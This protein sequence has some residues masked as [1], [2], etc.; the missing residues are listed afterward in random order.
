M[1]TILRKVFSVFLT[2]C[3]WTV[4]LSLSVLAAEGDVCEIVETGHE[5]S[6]LDDALA[7]VQDEETIR[8][9]ES[10]NYNCGIVIDAED[11]TFKL[12]EFTLNVVNNDGPGLRV[13]NGGAVYLDAAGTGAFN[14]TGKEF[15]V[16]V[17]GGVTGAATA[18]V[19][20]AEATAP[21]GCAA[22][23]DGENAVITVEGDVTAN[24]AGGIGAIGNSSGLVTVKGNVN[25]DAGNVD[26]EG[27]CEYAAVAAW[28]D[29]EVIVAGDVTATGEKSIGVLSAGSCVTVDG[30]VA[31]V[32]GGAYA[33]ASASIEI[34]GN[35]RSTDASGFGV[36]ASDYCGIDIGGNV[37]AGGTGVII[38]GVAE[39][40]GPSEIIIDGVIEAPEYIKIGE[41]TL[42]FEDY[43]LDPGEMP[44]YRIYADAS[45]TLGGVF[46]AEF[47]GGD[48]SE[49]SPYLVAHAYHL[50]NVRNYLDKCFR[51][52]EDI[53]LSSYNSDGGWEPLGTGD[54]S[55]TGIYDGD[56][57]TISNLF[58]SRNEAD[59]AGL[60]GRILC[61]AAGET[62]IRD[63]GLVNV[64][65]TSKGETGGLAGLNYGATMKNCY[66]T[67]TV[68]GKG[69]GRIGGLV[70]DNEGDIINCYTNATVEGDFE[71]LVDYV[72]G[73]V[74]MNFGSITDSHSNG[75]VSGDDEVGGLVGYNCAYEGSSGLISDSYSSC[76]VTGLENNVGGLVG[77]NDGTITDSFATGA[78]SG[79]IGVGGLVGITYG[80]ISNSYAAGEVEGKD[81]VGGLAG[82]NYGS[83][84]KSYATG[85]VT[86]TETD[87]D[88]TY[89]GGLVGSNLGPISDSYAR[90]AVF[91]QEDIGG[92]VGYNQAL[93]ANSYATGLVDGD[94]YIGGL[95]G[96]NH[97][98]GNI[99]NSYWDTE[100]SC[101]NTSDGG[102]GKTTAEMK[103][104]ATYGDWDFDTI[105]EISAD[106]N[107]GYPY[108][109]WLSAGLTDAE[110][111]A[112]DQTA[113]TFAAIKGENSEEGNIT[114]GLNLVSSG[115]NGTAI[116]WSVLPDEGW[117]NPATGAVTRPSF[118]TGS[119]AVTLT[120]T[121]SKGSASDTRAFDLVVASLPPTEA[122]AVAA[123]KVLLTW[124]SIKGANRSTDSVTTGLNLTSGGR[125]DTAI[126]WSV[127]P[128]ENWINP[129]TGAVTR[130]TSREGDQ[131]VTLTATIAKGEASDT[132]EFTL[133]VKAKSVGSGGGGS[134]TPPPTS[135]ITD[136][137]V[138]AGD[139]EMDDTLIDTGEAF[140]S[141]AGGSSDT[142]VI[143]G[144]VVNRLLEHAK[145]F[146]VRNT[147]IE[148]EFAPG[149]LAV[150][151]GDD[152]RVRIGVR[153][154]GGK[155]KEDILAALPPGE[156]S[157]LPAGGG[158]VFELTA[159]VR[160]AGNEERSMEFDVP[161][162]ITVDAA[163]LGDMTEEEIG[164]LSGVRLATDSTGNTVPVALGGNYDPEM[165]TFT[166][167]TNKPGLFTVMHLDSKALVI[168]L[169]VG[170]TAATVDGEPYPLDAVPYINPA[171]G[172]TLVPVRF[173]S[174]TFGAYVE[175]IEETRQVVIEE[176]GREIILTID[177]MTVT[178]DGAAVEID[179][180][181]ELQSGRSY[182][183]LRFVSEVLGAEVEYDNQTHGITVTR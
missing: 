172:R 102:E 105:W 60:F 137:V 50:Y 61:E 80:G 76:T 173:I 144:A 11:I 169:T 183:P 30:D 154:V 129:S 66:V 153:E 162:V 94:S 32:L 171:A 179:C 98:D 85:T 77:N 139:R 182:V 70:G 97:S 43:Y 180:A 17:E 75:D 81:H 89:V 175:W 57:H 27:E 25:A 107:D 166:F 181:P 59:P 142:T 55:F 96:F 99:T 118:G 49:G 117:I 7:A 67:G 31:G 86:G 44:G 167:G 138:A 21:E 10:I 15:G 52:I 42:A 170:S 174:E 87:I 3:L 131:T 69:S 6:T 157:G 100:A 64:N 41:D 46:V 82:Y 19:T 115:A 150:G 35:V 135:I 123:D 47:A 141:L 90:G 54:D 9:L 58:I 95:I 45:L 51:Q 28:D 23:A 121:I 79:N 134:S 20:A 56:G 120:A 33:T 110:A 88:Y 148:I 78:V 5:Y 24:G 109:R 62:E 91:G 136:V 156:S 140:I 73:L 119:Q 106:E 114:S 116:A 165:K 8:L 133:T 149:A 113:L 158:I 18:T 164:R 12:D 26:Y 93:V 111:V 128:D 112:A 130:P 126:T 36:L 37:E 13:I 40:D 74:G 53:D 155:E 152:V 14:V 38:I 68:E 132:V 124:N 16:Y 160:K 143:S 145:A 72:G 29:G 83:I 101:Q 71:M 176:G 108:L 151:S 4:P 63:L 122:E 104:Q 103:I 39:L 65:V 161:A 127:T 48:G 34:D 147:G 22:I 177:A 159:L 1:K 168:T 178:V 2:L 125:Y 84:D 146:A 92:L 163:S